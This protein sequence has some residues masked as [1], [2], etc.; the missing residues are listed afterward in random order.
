MKPYIS[1]CMIVKNEEKVLRRCLDSVKNIIEE[2]IIVDTGSTDN[3]KQIALDYAT[4]VF[5]YKWNN[6]FA[7]ARNFAQSKANGKW[8]IFLDA[9]E[10]VYSQNLI[11]KINEMKEIEKTKKYDA[12]VVEQVNFIGNSGEQVTNCSTI[13]IY[14][15]DSSIKFYRAIHEQLIKMGGSLSVGVMDL[16]IYH[17]GYLVKTQ[18]E[19]KKTDRNVNLI[20]R[21]LKHDSHGFDYYNMGNEYH[22]QG[23]IEEALNSYKK[24]YIN[25]EHI[26]VI[27]VPRVV[28]RIATCL[29][30]LERYSDAMEVLED[31]ELYWTNIAD[32][33]CLK[34][35]LFVYEHRYEDAES[36][37]LELIANK[38][39]FQTKH[40]INYLEYIPY[41][42]LGEIYEKKQDTIN[43]IKYFSL[44][45]NF[46]DQDFYILKKIYNLL[47][48]NEEKNN[49]IT[50][51][52][53][54]P[55]IDKPINRLLLLKALLD[56]GEIELVEHY[57]DK[58]NVSC[59]AAFLFK[60][61]LL[62]GE[63][64]KAYSL[65]E[66]N[67]FDIILEGGWNE[68]TDILILALQ[69]DEPQ[70]YSDLL[71]SSHEVESLNYFLN[72]FNEYNIEKIK[73]EVL[74]I[75]N[76]CIEYQK[77]DL[78]EQVIHKIS[79]LSINVELGNLLY[80]NGFKDLAL[81][82]YLQ[83]DDLIKLD[84][85]AYVNIIESFIEKDNKN[86]ALNF[87]FMAIE[88]DKIDYRIFILAIRILDEMNIQDDKDKLVDIAIKYYPGSKYLNVLKGELKTSR[89]PEKDL[90]NK[91]IKSERELLQN[92]NSLMKSQL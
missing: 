21:E 23:N 18:K 79:S 19:K 32:F 22:I 56:L 7:D 44:A 59:S 92:I 86:E 16:N 37:F 69:L 14:K 33:K 29:I 76:K 90:K 87:A 52:N 39:N 65:I 74:Y 47:V 89:K 41:R 24:A 46:N 15:N 68:Y 72:K 77:Y 78:F 35:Q 60:V 57:V 30:Q 8:I 4:E 28:E 62:K 26:D 9:D 40:S 1:L 31:A 91:N 64:R 51:I 3:T 81:D 10:F 54:Q 42:Y 34:G 67:S 12:F 17:S 20:Q 88:Q 6:N 61:Y 2:I 50:F 70:L 82:F 13:R 84:E 27:W 11:N 75:L 66:E 71:I 58:W 43:A 80:N 45:L 83:I 49:L 55:N 63:Y 25:K 85:Q 38:R 53:N 36:I 48:K 5:D 73:N